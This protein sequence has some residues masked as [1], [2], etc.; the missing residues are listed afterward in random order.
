MIKSGSAFILFFL[1]SFCLTQAQQMQVASFE[2][3]TGV[4]DRELIGADTVFSNTVG[5]IYCYTRIRGAEGSQEIVHV[6]YYEDQPQASI[7]LPVES[8]N[9]RTWSS[10]NIREDWTGSWRV[11]VEDGK[12]NIL[13]NKSFT[14]VSDE[15]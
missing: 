10:K 7:T 6:W 5:T 1:F 14:V 9:W 15:P 2:F 11:I 12:G 4:Q 8:S 3:G 13:A